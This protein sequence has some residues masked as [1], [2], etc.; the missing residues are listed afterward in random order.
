MQVVVSSAL[1]VHV[2]DAEDLSVW[3]TSRLDAGTR[4]LCQ[5][6]SG[7]CARPV[8]GEMLKKTQKRRQPKKAVCRGREY[9]LPETSESI[10]SK[11]R[12]PGS[13]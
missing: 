7:V 4:L 11:H 12:G 8:P 9:P 1:C 5:A 6:I 13:C 2:P 3:D 10:T